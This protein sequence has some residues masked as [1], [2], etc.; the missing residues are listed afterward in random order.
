MRREKFIEFGGPNGGDGGR[1]GSVYFEGDA[2]L[3]TLQDFR[4]H[5][6]QKAGNGMPGMGDNKTGKSG[7]DKTIGVP[8][9]TIVIDDDTDEILFE[10]L[11]EKRFLVLKGGRGGLGNVHFKSS[12]NQ[13]PR[14]AQPGEPGEEMTVRLELKIM[15]D[16]GL[17]GFPNAG[18]STFISSISNARPRIADYPFTTLVPNLGVVYVSQFRSFVVADIPGIIENAHKGT[19]LGDHFLRHIQRTSVLAFLIDSSDPTS[20]PPV[21]MFNILM[22]ELEKYSPDLPEKERIML[23]TKIDATHPGLN[24]EETIAAFR[25]M[26]EEIIPISSVSGK[27]LKKA[28]QRLAELVDENRLRTS[29]EESATQQDL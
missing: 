22:N 16:V 19:G 11:E 28:I 17:V 20:K 2:R 24:I 26:G 7:Q 18:K 27:G 21:E 4:T 23:L 15:A 1:G 25:E 9:G 3:N 5:P 6:H 13:A 12:T 14:Y 29:S 8:L 10:V